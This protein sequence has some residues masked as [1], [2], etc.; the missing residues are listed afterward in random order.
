MKNIL[1]LKN[2]KIFFSKKYI[3]KQKQF[4]DKNFRSIEKQMINI[5]TK[6]LNELHNVNYSSRFWKNY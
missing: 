3:E 6:T 1:D 2:K 5:L 4:H